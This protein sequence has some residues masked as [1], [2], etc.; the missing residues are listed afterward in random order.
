MV[1]Q[2]GSSHT[3][4]LLLTAQIKRVDLNN[5]KGLYSGRFEK[6]STPDNTLTLMVLKQRLDGNTCIKTVVILDAS[7]HTLSRRGLACLLYSRK[8]PSVLQYQQSSEY[9]SSV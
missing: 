4:T 6:E 9:F 7:L 5:V 8:C 3:Y 1:F 2:G